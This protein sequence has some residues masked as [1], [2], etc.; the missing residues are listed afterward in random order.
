MMIMMVDSSS[1]DK[2]WD[3]GSRADDIMVDTSSLGNPQGL[4]PRQKLTFKKLELTNPFKAR[5]W[6]EYSLT[7]FAHCQEFLPSQSIHL[8]FPPKPHPLSEQR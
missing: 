6:L 3:K 5:S 8:H 1:V 4:L 7:G 2:V